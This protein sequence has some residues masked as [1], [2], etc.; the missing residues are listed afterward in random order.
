MVKKILNKTEVKSVQLEI[1]AEVLLIWT[2]VTRTNV[3]WTNVTVTFGICF[4]CSQEHTFKFWSKSGQQQ[5]R[6]VCGGGGV[7]WKE[8]AIIKLIESSSA[9]LCKNTPIWIF[10]QSQSQ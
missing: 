1:T 10:C 6:K 3:A 2:N 9:D 7:G 4:R 5:L 8:T